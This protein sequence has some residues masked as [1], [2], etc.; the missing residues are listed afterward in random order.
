MKLAKR[1][2]GLLIEADSNSKEKRN[3]IKIDRKLA[4][5]LRDTKGANIKDM[6]S[7]TYKLRREVIDII[8]KIKKIIPELPRLQVRVV[9]TVPHIRKEQGWLGFAYTGQD[10]IFIDNEFI[11]NTGNHLE[12]VVA[13]E[14]IHAVTGAIHVEAKDDIMYYKAPKDKKS[15]EWIL[16]EVKKWYDRYKKGSIGA[17]GYYDDT[18]KLHKWAK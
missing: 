5:R 1:I 11:K 18:G 9:D 7:E 4:T 10:T 13:H 2:M 12:Y 17:N 15:L 3:T 6:D 16:S 8:Y 14:V